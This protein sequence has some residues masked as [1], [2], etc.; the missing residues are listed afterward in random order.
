MHAIAAAAVARAAAIG[1]EAWI[2]DCMTRILLR[3]QVRRTWS[4]EKRLRTQRRGEFLSREGKPVGRVHAAIPEAAD[5]PVVSLRVDHDCLGA[6]IP[7]YKFK[8]G[9]AARQGRRVEGA[10]ML[11]T[12]LLIILLLLI[13]GAVPAWP[14][15][16]SWGYYPSGAM[17]VL[18]VII[19]VLFLMGRI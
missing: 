10:L 4:I 8:R 1:P 9:I 7:L 19:L 14:Y 2:P 11:G 6:I 12:I 17:T 16:R 3:G 13:L 18:L 15:S 5:L